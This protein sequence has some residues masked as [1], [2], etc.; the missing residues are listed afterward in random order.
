MRTPWGVVIVVL[1][2][3]GPAGSGCG[4]QSD[5]SMQPGSDCLSCH[6]A[7]AAGAG[8]DFTAAG[9]VYRPD[10]DGAAGAVVILTDSRSVQVSAVTNSVGNFY[11]TEALTTPLRVEIDDGAIVKVMA[12]ATGACNACHSEEGSAAWPVLLP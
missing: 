8:L 3:L 5:G 11:V 1:A 4:D 9:T 10:G 2:A 12:R 6:T 7:G